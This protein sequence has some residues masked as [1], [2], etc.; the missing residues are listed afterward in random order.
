VLNS[1][2]LH[3]EIPECLFSEFFPTAL[4]AVLN[5]TA[6]T[7]LL[8]DIRHTIASPTHAAPSYHG[9]IKLGRENLL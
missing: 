7:I 3:V 9:A 6:F 4:R 1:Y 2:I 5:I 8:G